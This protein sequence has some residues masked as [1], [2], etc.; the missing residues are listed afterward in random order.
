MEKKVPEKKLS[1]EFSEKGFNDI[2]S[3]PIKI[4]SIKKTKSK[5]LT[6][7]LGSVNEKELDSVYTYVKK[8][9]QFQ[10]LKNGKPVCTPGGNDVITTSEP[11]VK[12]VV[13][14][15]NDIGE[16]YEDATTII[17]FLYSEIDFFEDRSRESLEKDILNDLQQIDWTLNNPYYSAKNEASWTKNFSSPDTRIEEVKTWVKSLNK[18]QTEGV[19]IMTANMSSPN[20]AFILSNNMSIEELPEFTKFCEEKYALHQKKAGHGMYSYWPYEQML[21]IFDN[22]IFWQKNG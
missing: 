15:M 14:Q 19:Y 4:K 1:S 9:E 21:M 5:G 6:I 20:L 10:V 17:S 3:T 12:A 8:G 18:H 13:G 7:E 11:L 16:Q 22:Y 2:K